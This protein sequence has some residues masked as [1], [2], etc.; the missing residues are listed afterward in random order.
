MRLDMG[1]LIE[2]WA[3]ERKVSLKKLAVEIGWDYSGL[4]RLIKRER[5]GCGIDTLLALA[6]KS[7]HSVVLLPKEYVG[8]LND[9]IIILKSMEDKQKLESQDQP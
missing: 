2:F 7:G 5:K 6:E 1:E 4:F 9:R 8:M 3:K